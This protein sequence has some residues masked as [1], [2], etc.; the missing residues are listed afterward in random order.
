MTG[1]K[2]V[3]KGAGTLLN[4]DRRFFL[5]RLMH[6]KVQGPA[7]LRANM[8]AQ[9]MHLS[10]RTYD[11]LLRTFPERDMR[12]LEQYRVAHV[13]N[14][15]TVILRVEDRTSALLTVWE[16]K[17]R[18]ARGAAPHWRDAVDAIRRYR[19]NTAVTLPKSVLIPDKHTFDKDSYPFYADLCNLRHATVTYYTARNE[20]REAYLRL[21]RSTR[22]YEALCELWPEA[23][24]VADKVLAPPPPAPAPMISM[25]EQFLLQM[26]QAERG[27]SR[28][29]PTTP[30]TE[31]V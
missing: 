23:A 15:L 30:P 6:E 21:I 16:E 19:Y 13:V 20:I 26:D 18:T 2:G 8:E 31:E 7:E 9:R 27:V 17:L 14:D 10:V 3:K 25:Q 24:E 28:A 11:W 22:T 1:T 5:E 4:L 12:V 29:A